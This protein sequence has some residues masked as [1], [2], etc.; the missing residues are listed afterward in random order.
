VH[1]NGRSA[2]VALRA[3]FQWFPST[4]LVSEQPRLSPPR[5]LAYCMIGEVSCTVKAAAQ[6]SRRRGLGFGLVAQNLL[7]RHRP[8]VL[9]WLT[10]ATRA[11]TEQRQRDSRTDWL[12]DRQDQAV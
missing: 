12:T 3:M 2:H 4:H 6:R 7:V 1:G 11:N 10:D 9:A 8:Q 5:A